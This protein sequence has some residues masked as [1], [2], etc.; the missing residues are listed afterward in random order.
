MRIGVG[1]GLG[2]CATAGRTDISVCPINSKQTRMLALFRQATMPVLLLLR[3]DNR[4]GPAA[5]K[6]NRLTRLDHHQRSGALHA[7]V[8]RSRNSQYFPAGQVENVQLAVVAETKTI[9]ADSELRSVNRD[10]GICNE[11][12]FILR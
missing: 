6:S 10:R 4:I 9:S 5:V 12:T 1:L 3:R 11:K 8:V 2:C 7:F